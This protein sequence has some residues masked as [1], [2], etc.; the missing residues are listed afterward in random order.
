MPKNAKGID[1]A[2]IIPDK[3]IGC[4]LCVG[5][6]PVGAIFM[7]EGVARINPELCTGCGK[8]FD[9]CPVEAVIFEKPKEK[10]VA[11][12]GIPPPLEEYK[13]I[14]VFIEVREGRGAEVSWELVGKA[15]QLA[16]KLDTQVFG[17]LPGK[18][19]E[20]IAREA[21]AYGCNTVYVM[22]NPLLQTY[23]SKVYGK[24]LVQLCEQ[25][26]PEILLLGATPLG[27]DLAGVVATQLETGLTADC[28]GLDVAPKE[29]LLLMTRPT[30]G[31]NIMATILCQNHRPQMS[32]VRP[33]VMKLPKKDVGRN[34]EIHKLP[35]TVIEGELPKVIDFIPK[36]A[37]VGGVD[38][39]RAPVLVVV[40]K[41]ACDARHLPMLEE[42]AR[43][44]GG[45]I[46]CSRPVVESGL[47]PY[48]R[49]VGQTG[50]TVAPKL[51]IGVAVSGAVQHLAGMQGAEKIIAINIDRH[52]SM[53]Q[54]ADYALI[55]DYTKVVPRL[56]E[57]IEA[58]V[59][60]LKGK[61]E[62]K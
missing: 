58:R 39:T 26:K 41:G 57:G 17:F 2:E 36:V 12:V 43:L 60:S 16:E 40:G 48:I 30:F 32:T 6:C 21:I 27:R 45:T 53:V 46:G 44:L 47:L 51:Y 49:Q 18:E 38:I 31:G 5:E 56:I 9:I 55:G 37:E 34:G 8:C 19:V 35:F 23:L 3:C 50:K 52:A 29:R 1:I 4:Q 7:E 15:R 42:F 22:D 33:G 61:R 20:T 14:A 25:V 24:A 28:T 10:K 62:R 59:Q 54:I 11:G 13:G